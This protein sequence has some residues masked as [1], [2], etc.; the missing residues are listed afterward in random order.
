MKHYSPDEFLTLKQL[1]RILKLDPRTVKRVASQLG[2]RRMG[3]CWRFNWGAVL[4]YFHADIET[5]QGRP[6]AGPR[7]ARWETDR[8]QNVPSRKKILT[9]MAGRKKMGR[10]TARKGSSRRED[11]H[12]LGNAYGLGE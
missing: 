1:A 3:Q 11:P 12:G 4:E 6:L 9:T 2:G 7:S 5:R 10:G 8:L